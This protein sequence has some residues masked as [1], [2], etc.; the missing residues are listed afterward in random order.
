MDARTSAESGFVEADGARLEFTWFG[1]GDRASPI[2]LLHEGLG[3]ISMWKS[4]P[5]NLAA[6]T[7]SAVLAYSRASYGRSSPLPEPRS[8]GYMHHEAGVVLPTVLNALGIGKPILLGHSDGAS[9]ALIFAGLF[10][11][12]TRAVILEAPHVFVEPITV[13]SI[14]EAKIAYQTTD[15]P[16]K[17]GR[18][19]SDVDGA[20]WRWNDVW[21]DPQFLAWNIEEYLSAIQCPVLMIQGDQDEYGTRA[22]LD[23]IAAQVADTRIVMLDQCRHSPHRDQQAATL[24]GIEEFLSEKVASL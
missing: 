5:Q 19:H 20:F 12:R 7:G 3:S 21:L 23:A 8:P 15:L 17:L 22:Q 24:A 2:V 16:A 14:A 11:G 10:P 18:Y 6:R 1:R 9:I 13:S 4:F